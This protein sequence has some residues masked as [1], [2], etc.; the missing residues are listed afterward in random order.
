ML[1]AWATF[2]GMKLTRGFLW[3]AAVL[4]SLTL[5]L[6]GCSGTETPNGA[7]STTSTSTTAATTTATSSTTAETSTTAGTSTA[8]ADLSMEDALTTA[9]ATCNAGSRAGEQD[10]TLNGV[11]F[12]LSSDWSESATLRARACSEGYIDPGF[13]VLTDGTSYVFADYHS[14][15]PAI[16]SALKEQGVS[17]KTTNYCP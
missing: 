16:A 7:D 3:T 15:Y 1:I 11:S 2:A 8:E 4:S 6:V 10:C 13:Q 17:T 5:A 14:D 9:G 12:S